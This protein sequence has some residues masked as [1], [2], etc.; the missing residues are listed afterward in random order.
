M[1]TESQLKLMVLKRVH[2]GSRV[3]SIALG[4]CER[5]IREGVFPD[6]HESLEISMMLIMLV[7]DEMVVQINEVNGFNDGG[8][9]RY[10]LT[11]LGKSILG[12]R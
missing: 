5:V 4:A 3:S 10:Q 12:V 2:T 8:T 1:M 11:K 6:Q 9:A 7:E